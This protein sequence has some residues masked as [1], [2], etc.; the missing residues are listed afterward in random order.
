M[1]CKQDR[2]WTKNYYREMAEGYLYNHHI[3]EG[4]L[5]QNVIFGRYIRQVCAGSLLSPLFLVPPSAL[6]LDASAAS[7]QLVLYK[8]LEF[9]PRAKLRQ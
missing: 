7:A 4:G 2:S 9:D 3:S 5:L 6:Y 8:R 1:F